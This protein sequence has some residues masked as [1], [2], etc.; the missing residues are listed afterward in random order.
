MI[1]N[2]LSGCEMRSA[3]TWSGS[4]PRTEYE[5]DFAD[6]EWREFSNPTRDS[7][8]LAS[9]AVANARYFSIAQRHRQPTLN[10]RMQR[11]EWDLLRMIAAQPFERDLCDSAVPA[12]QPPAPHPGIDR[13]LLHTSVNTA[14]QAIEEHFK[15]GQWRRPGTSVF[16]PRRRPLREERLF[17]GIDLPPYTE[18]GRLSIPSIHQPA[19]VIQ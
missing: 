1:R 19:G 8:V 11:L 13:R 2:G 16:I 14:K 10:I 9:P 6:G 12:L 17:T 3:R 15:T 7:T 5:A 4:R 18:C